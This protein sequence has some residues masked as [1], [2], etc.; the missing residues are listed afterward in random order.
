MI[1]FV[2]I[3]LFLIF[4]SAKFAESNK[5][6]A[7]YI[8]KDKTNAV[9]GI[10]VVLI[11]FSHGKQYMSL[12]GIYDQAYIMLQNH[13][14][15]M[16]VAMF[17]FYSGYGIMESIK[18]KGYDYVKTI[19]AK[20]FPSTLLNFDIAIALYLLVGLLL[21]NTYDIKTILLSLIGFKSV[22]NSNWYMFAI[23]V[24]YILTFLSFLCRKWI[25][26]KRADLLC[27]IILTALTVGMVFAEMKAGMQAYW[28]NTLILFALGFY[29][30]YFKETIEKVVMKND[31]TY[32]FI[33]LI[34]VCV[35]IVSYSFRRDLGIEV[36]TVWAIAFTL[37]TVILTMKISIENPLLKWLG[38]HVFSIYILQRIPM[39]VLAH[40][41]LAQTHKY[42]FLIVSITAT[43]FLA[44]VFDYFT[45]KLSKAIWKERK[46]A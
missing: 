11:L 8:S 29:Y 6:A 36:Y 35:Y 20:R 44:T 41:Q 31:I 39:S 17:L 22:G 24:L 45:A 1:F 5:F 33:L 9:K 38:Q 46:S 7:D 37:L 15:Q 16:V 32:F 12:E 3:L 13:L 34:T 30:S 28:Y 40:Y 21:G 19:P 27:I 14:D 10:F 18:R 25:K 23:F 26:N 43:L 42:V 4:N 2:L